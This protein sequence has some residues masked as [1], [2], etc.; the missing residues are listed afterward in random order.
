MKSNGSILPHNKDLLIF[1]S[2]FGLLHDLCDILE[3]F[4]L[5]E[6]V[7]NHLDIVAVMD[8][9]LDRTVKH[10][11]LR[12]NGQTVDVNPHLAG[13]NLRNVQEHAYAVDSLNADSGIEEQLLVHIP[14]GIEDAIAETGLQPGSYRTGTLVNLY[15]MTPIDKAKYII[16]RNGVTA[17]LELILRDILVGDE[18]SLLAIEILRHDKDFLLLF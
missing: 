5:F 1:S 17:V 11:I 7:H 4:N 9:Q 12:G 2:L 14:L 10:T 13:D 6:I 15:L 16:A 18:D 3:V 8:T